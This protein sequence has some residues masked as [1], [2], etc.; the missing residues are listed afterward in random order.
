MRTPLFRSA[1][2][3]LLVVLCLVTGCLATLLLATCSG[4]PSSRSNSITSMPISAAPWRAGIRRLLRQSSGFTRPDRGERINLQ[5]N[6]MLSPTVPEIR[7]T[8]VFQCTSVSSR[9]VL[10]GA[11]CSGDLV[12]RHVNYET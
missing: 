3:T 11:L 1:L 9:E 6:P 10:A 2:P 7:M 8:P 4:G 12:Q 5:K